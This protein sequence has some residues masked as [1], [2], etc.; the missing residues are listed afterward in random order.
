MD[1]PDS[2][3]YG[4]TGPCPFDVIPHFVV[5]EKFP[6][7]FMHD[8]LEGT[9]PHIIKLLLQQFHR[10]K[11]VTLHKFSTQLNKLCF[12]QNDR[13]RKPVP[14]K[15]SVHRD[16]ALPGKAIEK[17]TL[18]CLLPLMI[19][20]FVPKDSPHWHL[21]LLLQNI[22]DIILA[23]QIKLSWLGY[24]SSLISEFLAEL[25]LLLPGK[26]TPKTHY[27]VHYPQLISE[28]GPLR[29]HW[30]IRFEAKHLYFKQLS[31]V[32]C[33]FQNISLTLA[34]R[35]QM[36]QCYDIQKGTATAVAPGACTEVPLSRLQELKE[37]ITSKDIPNETV[38]KTQFL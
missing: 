25:Q 24:L 33:N 3:A 35:Y 38:W 13:K 20:R 32:V 28:F 18:F 26:F 22:C 2:Q 19:G 5:S 7:D 17:W 31:S 37:G 8:I 27:L 12:G 14:L 23:P 6:P 4:V 15:E 11:I 34:K 21:Y 9:I 30:C 36:C 29:A 10:E 1:H 16:A